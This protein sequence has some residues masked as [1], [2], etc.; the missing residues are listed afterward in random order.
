MQETVR[1]QLHIAVCDDEEQAGRQVCALVSQVLLQKNMDASLSL[2]Q[3]PQ[4]LMDSMAATRYDLF[5]LD[6]LMGNQNGI[7]LAQAL[8]ARGSQ[9]K[10]I[11]ITSSRDFAYES[12][13]VR[14]DDYL[15][16]P[17]TAEALAEALER[18]LKFRDLLALKTLNGGVHPIPRDEIAWAEVRDH[19][20][21]I[22]T[23]AEV[24]SVRG[25]LD[26]IARM[27]PQKD[28]IRCQ[29]SYLVNLDFV[30]EVDARSVRLLDGTRIPISRSL[31]RT[32][33]EAVIQH[34]EDN[35]PF[36]KV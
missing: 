16:K 26:E 12:Y 8:R 21:Q 4:A 35:I 7:A 24:V 36:L 33:K 15:L 29:R 18:L 2:F 22:H 5:L 20:V 3:S 27:L 1:P 13:R 19:T 25:T 23:A 6:I 34:T 28:F 31:A 9:A 10:L 11:F 30:A 17:I 14:A 32:V